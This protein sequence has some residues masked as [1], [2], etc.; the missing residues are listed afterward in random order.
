MLSLIPQH[1]IDRLPETY[2]DPIA[3]ANGEHSTFPFFDLSTGEFRYT[4]RSNIRKRVSREKLR[5]LLMSD[6]DIQVERPGPRLPVIVVA[7]NFCRITS[8]ANP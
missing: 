6:L 2:C 1:L 8:G 7:T 5:E 3:T 4:L